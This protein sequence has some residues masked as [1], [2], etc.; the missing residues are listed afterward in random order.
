MLKK[1]LTSQET[2]FFSKTTLHHVVS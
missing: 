2:V 1:I